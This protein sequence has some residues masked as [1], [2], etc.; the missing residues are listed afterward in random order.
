MFTLFICSFVSGVVM[1]GIGAALPSIMTE[2]SLTESMG[3][4][5]A[6]AY[7]I[8]SMI[9]IFSL[10]FVFAGL[11]SRKSIMLYSA[12]SAAALTFFGTSQG[13]WSAWIANLLIG[14]ANGSLLAYP[15]MIATDM[16]GKKTAKLV[17]LLYG[18]FA[19]GVIVWPPLEG[20]IFS[21]GISWRMCFF[22]PAVVN[23]VLFFLVWKF[24]P[25]DMKTRA[26]LKISGATELI[27]HDWKLFIAITLSIFMY[28]AAENT[29][30]A[31][32]PK[33]FQNVF[34]LSGAMT[35]SSVL[36]IF[37]IG[38][39]LGRIIVGKWFYHHPPAPMIIVLGMF[40]WVFWL[41]I[42]FFNAQY[43]MIGAIGFLGLSFSAI[44]PLLTSCS[45]KFPGQGSAMVFSTC[46]ATGS[47]GGALGTSI[48]GVLAQL[49]N[50]RFALGLCSLFIPA[51]L[52]I[53]I[54]QLRIRA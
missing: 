32:G 25:P 4:L 12:L 54:R 3:G 22:I 16:G 11:S 39:A 17:N 52:F 5:L 48:F 47:L 34:P 7:L 43:L 42:V 40:S 49:I 14:L 31:W 29:F 6:S 33:Y 15:G 1:I 53:V 30:N 51:M 21:A 19:I 23:I 44:W 13:F 2:M 8:G 37:W 27:R 35:S 24:P 28:V 50:F 26:N 46:V 10:N 38:L 45:S 36:S 20:A 18:I 41:T 9:A